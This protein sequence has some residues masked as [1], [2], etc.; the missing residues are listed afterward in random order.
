VEAS[1]V[2]VLTLSILYLGRSF[3]LVPQYRSLVAGGPY[4]IVRHPMYGSYVVFDGTLALGSGSWAARALWLLEAV[5]LLLRAQR[6]EQ[7]LEANEPTYRTYIE[8]VRYRFVPFV[9]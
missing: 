2:I 6:E 9:V 5:L 3:S 7:L 4:A 1:A 8:R